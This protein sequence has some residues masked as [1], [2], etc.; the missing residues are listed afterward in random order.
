[1]KI[2][3]TFSSAQ[4][5]IISYSKQY[6]FFV[7]RYFVSLLDLLQEK[8]KLSNESHDRSYSLQ[9]EGPFKVSQSN[10]GQ[11]KSNIIYYI[12]PVVDSISGVNSKLLEQNDRD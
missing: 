6:D 4:K 2:K 10:I 7:P 12:D 8:S 11:D 9:S 5:A 1:M 3:L